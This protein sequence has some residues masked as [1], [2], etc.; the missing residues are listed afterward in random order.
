MD[1]PIL[2]RRLPFSELQRQRSRAI[3]YPKAQCRKFGG[4]NALPTHFEV[5]VG[6]RNTPIRR[7]AGLGNKINKDNVIRRPKAA[8]AGGRQCDQHQRST[9][10]SSPSSLSLTMFGNSI[11][12]PTA[13]ALDGALGTYD[14]KTIGRFRSGY[15]YPGISQRLLN[16]S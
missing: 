15:V 6:E 9:I 8:V 7:Q 2:L 16:K 1:R 14:M 4:K 12:A 5:F 13:A 10:N 11:S 3:I